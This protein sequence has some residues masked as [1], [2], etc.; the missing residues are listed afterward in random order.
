MYCKQEEKS[1]WKKKMYAQ[2]KRLNEHVPTNIPLTLI[3]LKST[4]AQPACCSAWCIFCIS[5]A[6]A[7]FYLILIRIPY[8]CEQRSKIPL[9]FHSNT[10]SSRVE[11]KRSESFWRHVYSIFRSEKELKNFSFHKESRNWILKR[12]I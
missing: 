5:G 8:V 11:V 1:T 9:Y 12:L 2:E 10:T 6:W 3:P 7:Y 4:V